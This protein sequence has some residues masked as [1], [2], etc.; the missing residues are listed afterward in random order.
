M[1]ARNR[2]SIKE[3]A[4]R[5]GVAPS[6]VSNALNDVPEARVAEKTRYRIKQV[7]DEMGYVPNSFARALRTNRSH[8]LALL[9]DLVAT[10]PYAGELVRGAHEAAISRGF[11]LMIVTTGNDPDVQALGIRALRQR[12]MDGVLYAAMSH[13]VVTLPDSLSSGPL[14]VVNARSTDSQQDCV[15]PDEFDGGYS[16][17]KVMLDAG[18]RRIGLV[19]TSEFIPARYGRLDGYR[20]ALAEA[21]VEFHPELVAEGPSDSEGGFD[22]AIQLLSRHDRPTGLFCFNDRM[23]MG[24]FRAARRLGMAIPTDVSIV[25]FDNLEI[26]AG[27]LDPPLTTIALPYYE[28]GAWG[29][30]RVIDKI[31]GVGHEDSDPHVALR[32]T[33]VERSSV[34]RPQG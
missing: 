34:A 4:A 31:M 17:T 20:A 18:H 8:T 15:F 11:L 29:V 24:A 25:G 6:T 32:G 14:V 30:N 2:P 3:I 9:S 21:G 7:A 5:A 28:M 13:R 26:I 16:A 23:A 10:T 19:L 22:A 27:A 1:T 12:Q 33:L